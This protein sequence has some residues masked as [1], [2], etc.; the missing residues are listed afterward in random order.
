LQENAYPLYRRRDNGRHFIKQG[1][2]FTNQHVVPYNR[3]LLLKYKCHFNVEI[4]QGIVGY[5]YIYK[6]VSKGHDRSHLEMRRAE[7]LESGVIDGIDDD[8]VETGT[9]A[10]AGGKKKVKGRNEVKDFVD[11]RYIGPV[12]GESY[13]LTSLSYS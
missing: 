10:T 3:F 11:G 5:K 6:Y 7:D 8:E 4:A 12:E 1:F 2:T 13:F 9:G